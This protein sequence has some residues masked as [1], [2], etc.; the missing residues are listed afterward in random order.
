M[1]GRHYDQPRSRQQRLKDDQQIM[2]LSRKGIPLKDIAH[3]YGLSIVGTHC[4]AARVE[5]VYMAW[6]IPLPPKVKAKGLAL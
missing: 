3:I 4:A 6:N 1:G 5:E 2:I